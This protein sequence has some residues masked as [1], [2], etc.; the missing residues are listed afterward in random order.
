MVFNRM[1]QTSD[2]LHDIYLVLPQFIIL[3]DKIEISSNALNKL[4]MHS[5]RIFGDA[6]INIE[7][8]TKF[9]WNNK[10]IH[11]RKSNT[12]PIIRIYAEAKDEETAQDLINKVKSFMNN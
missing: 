9:T 1:A 8:G 6:N 2:S 3:K 5:K 7:D 10:W 12:E 11:L 4:I